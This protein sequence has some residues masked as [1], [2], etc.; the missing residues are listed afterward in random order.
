MLKHREGWRMRSSRGSRSRT[1]ESE[2]AAAEVEPPLD[3]A[4]SL[5][6]AL[7]P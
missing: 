5:N 7:A 1:E 3:A 4:L 6:E 2:R